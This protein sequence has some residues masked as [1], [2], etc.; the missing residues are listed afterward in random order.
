M[1]GVISTQIIFIY[2]LVPGPMDAN[3]NYTSPFGYPCGHSTNVH[4][5]LGGEGV[6]INKICKVPALKKLIF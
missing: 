3:A 5:A 6:V 4:L 2:L 1:L